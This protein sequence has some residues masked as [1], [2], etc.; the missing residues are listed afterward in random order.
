[1]Y[2]HKFFF[3]F[4]SHLVFHLHST[5]CFPSPPATAC[6]STVSDLYNNFVYQF[7]DVWCYIILIEE[8][9]TSSTH[10]IQCPCHFDSLTHPIS[11][12]H[13]LTHFAK[14]WLVT[15]LFQVFHGPF[16]DNDIGLHTTWIFITPR[17]MVLDL[18]S[19]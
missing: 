5:H 14:C 6:Y 4:F 9:L 17:F 15:L 8:E 7:R 18:G 11:L 19:K 12:R 3:L 13:A 16:S 2:V 1:M 10:L